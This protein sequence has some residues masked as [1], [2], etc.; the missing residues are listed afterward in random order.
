[1]FFPTRK[2]RLK[3]QT[4][5]RWQGEHNWNMMYFM[6]VEGQKGAWDHKKAWDNMA[7]Y[8][9]SFLVGKGLGEGKDRLP[10]VFA[11]VLIDINGVGGPNK[12]RGWRMTYSLDG[13]YVFDPPDA[14]G[15][16]S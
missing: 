7:K 9:D 14:D 6:P 16:S 8:M 11:D 15:K 2:L 13:H 5:L 10:E 12:R 4:A 1:M 3:P